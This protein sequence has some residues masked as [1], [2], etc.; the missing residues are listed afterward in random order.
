MRIIEQLKKSADTQFITDS[1]PDQ[2]YILLL[3]HGAGADMKHPFLSWL[4]SGISGLN[5][6]VIRYNFPYMQQG[7]KFPGSPRP[8]IEAIGRMVEYARHTFPGVPLFLSGKS[9]GG[10]MSS[11][12]VAENS[13]TTVNGLI[14]FGFPLHAAGKSSKERANHLYAITTPQ[15]FIQGTRD[16]LADFT[17]IREVIINCRKA[18]LVTIEGGDHSFKAP[19]S[20]K[21]ES[22]TK[23]IDIFQ[24][25]SE[26][27]NAWCISHL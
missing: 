3:A 18:S 20:M 6:T 4:A 22:G 1:C 10:R 17:L 8:N 5:G 25:L 12:W 13:E 7:K 26:E 23:F 9:Y 2:K 15:L 11:H 16:S 19:K 14:Y 27:T 21:T 24:K